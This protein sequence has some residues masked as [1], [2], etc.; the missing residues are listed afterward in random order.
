MISFLIQVFA[1]IIGLILGVIIYI[2]LIILYHNIKD[3][4]KNYRRK[5]RINKYESYKREFD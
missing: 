1:N 2:G 5:R 4:I 3:R